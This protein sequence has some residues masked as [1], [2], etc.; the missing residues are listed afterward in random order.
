MPE[1]IINGPEGRIEGRYLHA[2]KPN[3]PI[4]LILHPHPQHG[5]TM[6]NKVVYTLY[7]TFAQRGFACLRFNFRGVGRSQG[8]F[9][10]GEGE[11]SDAA[12]ALDW[13]QSHNESAPQ[14]WVAGFSFGAW[15]GMQLLMRRP[16]INSFISVA[17]PANMFDFSFL[18]PCPS[19]GLIMHGDKDDIVP[20]ASVD[21][22]IDKLRQQKGITIDLKTVRGANHFF[23]GH[24]DTL[25]K[26]VGNY[27]AAALA[28][29]E[30]AA[31]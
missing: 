5:G 6:N 19:S 1:I 23:Q 25:D 16:E 14:C 17:P 18:A 8:T 15:I 24:T 31:T 12:S 10:R 27:V 13:L 28:A 22:L 26:H 2:K 20:T 29:E 30:E 11:L 21:K 9:S 7:H 3:A 4:A